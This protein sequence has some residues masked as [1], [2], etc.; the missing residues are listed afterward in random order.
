MRVQSAPIICDSTTTLFPNDYID[1]KCNNTHI[2]TTVVIHPNPDVQW[3]NPSIIH[4]VDGRVRIINVSD[5]P[6]SLQQ[7]QCVASAVSIPDSDF[8]SPSNVKPDPPCQ[9]THSYSNILTEIKFNPQNMDIDPIWQPK[10]EALHKSHG[11]VFS[12]NL[13]GY[14]GK[15][16][17][18]SAFV[19]VGDSLPPQRR[20]RIPQYSRNLLS[21]LQ[22]QFDK[23]EDMGVFG[24]PEEVG[25][26]PEYVNPSFLVRKP[27]SDELRLVTSFGEVA[28]H[29]KPTPTLTP[30]VDGIIRHLGSWKYIIKT[31]LRKAYFQITLH[32]DSRK[33]CAVAT[34][35]RGT[36]CYLRAAMGMPGSESALDELLSRV[37][38]DL[39][40]IG[41]VQRLADD[42]YI[43]SDDVSSLYTAWEKVL[44]RL[45]QS[46]LCLSTAKTVII[47][48]STTILGWVWSNGLLSI[49]PHNIASLSSCELSK[50]IKS[51]RS[52]I[53]AYKVVSCILKDCS[54]YLAPLDSLTAGKTSAEH[55]N[56]DPDTI[57]SFKKSQKHLS[58]CSPI[59]LPTS[60]DKLWIISDACSS[61]PGIS[62]TLI[63]TDIDNSNPRLSSFFSAK[64][65]QGHN[66]WLPCEI[67]C[68]AI[69]SAITH[70]RLLILN[71]DHRTSVLT[72]SKPVV[73][74]FQKFLRGEFCCYTKQYI[75]QPH[76]R[77]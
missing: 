5:L 55:V 11:T 64:L 69:A 63:A 12:N 41:S 19:N 43:G 14:N 27:D 71:S 7:N 67:E 49:S 4:S 56:W 72:D 26:Y 28:A 47:L 44:V 34:P 68:L 54:Q 25:S 20:G 15:F 77:I 24:K 58:N 59:S 76:K 16:G 57:S 45:H 18:I 21:E 51:L 60:Q 70:F 50:T 53:G 32:P 9:E 29:N 3:I 52:Y 73:Q 31:D 13:P 6:V 35:F 8:I 30:N 74:A 65:K 62:A 48:A 39:I 17:P 10:F 75:H 23:L 46:D 38:G 36:R 66:K 40:E 1:V 33:Y 61:K 22:H 42:L 37:L 2:D